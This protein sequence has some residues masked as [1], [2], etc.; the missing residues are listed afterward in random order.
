VE[1]ASIVDARDVVRLVGDVLGVTETG[2][3]SLT[4]AVLRSLEKKD[5][6]VV[7]DNCEHVIDTVSNLV[8][9]VVDRCPDVSVIATSREGL[10]IHDEL[11]VAVRPLSEN[12]AALELFN[13]GAVAVDQTF[14]VEANRGTVEEL[15]RSLDGMQ[16]AIE[17]AAARV[18][19]LSPRDLAQRLDERHRSLR[20]AIEWYA[21]YM[22]QIGSMLHSPA[23][24]EGVA[25][26]NEVWDN[27]R[28]A[29]GWAC[30]VEDL[31]LAVALIQP[32]AMELY[33]RARTEL[34]DW[35][36]RILELPQTVS[37]PWHS[38]MVHIAP[39]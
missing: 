2:E 5:C 38:G 10:G 7:L 17:L 21:D 8:K 34:G 15:C 13:E 33:W 9:L 30:A 12:G 14:D 23:E 20:T 32:A 4:E 19:T 25:R 39:V 22:D 26:A 27:L 3:R 29:H 16:L 31:D 18:R 11:L 1:L 36:E 37:H 24:V 35:M 6:V 28:V